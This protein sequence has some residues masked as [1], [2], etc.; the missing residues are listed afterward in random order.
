M[1]Q[2]IVY[3]FRSGLYTPGLPTNKDWFWYEYINLEKAYYIYT[4]D[5]PMIKGGSDS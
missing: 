4:W 2:V 3:S 1:T 5:L